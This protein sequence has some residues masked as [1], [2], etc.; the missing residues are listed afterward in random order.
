MTSKTRPGCFSRHCEWVR[1]SGWKMGTK[2]VFVSVAGFVRI[3]MDEDG[4][5]KKVSS[6]LLTLKERLEMCLGLLFPLVNFSSFGLTPVLPLTTILFLR[7][8]LY[9]LCFSSR[10]MYRRPPCCV[11]LC[12]ILGVS[13]GWSTSS[14]SLPES[15]VCFC[16]LGTSGPCQT[17]ATPWLASQMARPYWRVIG[18]TVTGGWG[19]H[20]PTASPLLKWKRP[21]AAAGPAPVSPLLLQGSVKGAV[22][23]AWLCS[24]VE[25]S[26]TSPEVPF[27]SSPHTQRY[28]HSP[29]FPPV[30]FGHAFSQSQGSLP[31]FSVFGRHFPRICITRRK[32]CFSE[33]SAQ[34]GCW[35]VNL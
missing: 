17:S 28:L 12:S 25:Q 20:A 11:G 16:S 32:N 15:A 7:V 2:I 3:C 29:S 35:Q 19:L 18:S 9:I 27:P 33:V 13:Y 23:L 31:S 6:F 1:I 26:P 4:N 10:L 30:L 24:K 21:V 22:L 34:L 8:H 5:E 14:Y